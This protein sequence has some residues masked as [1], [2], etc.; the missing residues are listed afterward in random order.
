MKVLL[1]ADG[2]LLNSHAYFL[3]S[4]NNKY[5]DRISKDLGRPLN[6]EDITSWSFG[7]ARQIAGIPIIKKSS[8]EPLGAVDYIHEA[9]TQLDYNI[10]LVDPSAAR[11]ANYLFDN[12]DTEIVTANHEGEGLKKVLEN[13][14]IRTN[15]FRQEIKKDISNY[16]VVVE[17]NPTLSLDE[18][19]TLLLRDRPWN[20]DL[21]GENVLR[22]YDS[23][24]LP[25]VLRLFESYG[26]LREMEQVLSSEEEIGC[27]HP[28][29]KYGI[30]FLKT[31]LKK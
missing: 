3:D 21:S 18:N 14:G 17:D 29:E 26:N 12:F 10:D 24:Q 22:F 25:G 4:V 2:V 6:L 20:R 27:E 16:D 8:N 7:Q 9:Y 15:K 23:L 13:H 28:I 30:E 19:Q 1:D 5:A 11:V 31:N